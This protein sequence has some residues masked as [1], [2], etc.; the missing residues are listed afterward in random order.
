MPDNKRPVGFLG[1]AQPLWEV[2]Q[3]STH[4]LGTQRTQPSLRPTPQPLSKAD[5]DYWS[6]GAELLVT[7][8][9]AHT[10]SSRGHATHI[11]F[12]WRG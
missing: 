12:R 9:V 8:C 6:V 5:S 7:R 2:L 4:P 3:Q 11:Q 1:A 10:L